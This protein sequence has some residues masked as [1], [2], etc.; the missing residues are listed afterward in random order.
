MVL[1]GGGVTG[2]K[3]GGGATQAGPAALLPILTKGTRTAP[4]HLIEDHFTDRHLT[5]AT[6]VQHISVSQLIGRQ[7]SFGTAWVD[8]MS[9][10]QMVFDEMTWN[11]STQ[12][13]E[14]LI[15]IV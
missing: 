10:G 5:D 1:G 8:Q 2:L 11:W 4:R 12:F 14:N 13:N 6:F 9:V 15:R 7:V 3:E